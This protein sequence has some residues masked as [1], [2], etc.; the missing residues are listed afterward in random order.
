MGLIGDLLGFLGL[1]EISGVDYLFAAMAIVGTFLFM[2]YFLLI[3]VGG[4]ADGA[5]EIVGFDADFDIG[6]EGIFHMLTLQGILSFVMMFGIFG[7]AVSQSGGLPVVAILA[8]T[9]AGVSSMWLIGKVFQMMKGLEVDATVQHSQAIGAQGQ[10]YMTILPGETGQVQVE[11]QGALRT[12]T[13][14]LE[15][16]KETLKTGK[17]VE[18]IRT[19]GETLI[20]Q[21]LN[22]KEGSA[23]WK[24]PD[25]LTSEK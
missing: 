7:L 24:S 16:E 5:M 21:E 15:D 10:V 22:L 1:G 3:L 4:A 19:I 11:F 18:V 25:A 2:I 6:A 14:V 13:A 9:A 17:F 12:C 23:E 20:V 8:G